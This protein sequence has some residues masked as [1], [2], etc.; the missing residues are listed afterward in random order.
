MLARPAVSTGLRA[1]ALAA[2]LLVAA[3]SYLALAGAYHM[4]WGG[5]SAPARF[6][7]PVVLM[8]AA[9]VAALWASATTFATRGA[10]LATL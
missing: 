5:H 10:A 9:P 8:A 1:R 3:T 7:V 6:A 2:T 4:W